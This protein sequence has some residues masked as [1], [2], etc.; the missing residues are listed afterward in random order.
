MLCFA[1][2]I[3]VAA[4]GLSFALLSGSDI[5]RADLSA[6]EVT[7][8]GGGSLT[9]L[10]GALV[11]QNNGEPD[12]FFGDRLDLTK[13]G[14]ILVITITH[15][16]G[17]STGLHGADNNALPGAMSSETGGAAYVFTRAGDGTWSQ[18]ADVKGTNPASYQR[19][20]ALA[21]A[22]ML[23]VAALLDQSDSTGISVGPGRGAC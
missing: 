4:A 21:Y 8:T 6:E 13:G 9:G 10:T 22:G 1:S 18:K 11:L 7:F 15:E 19:A 12:V 20:I 2:A 23:A 16:A 17:G 5:G 3:V 14:R